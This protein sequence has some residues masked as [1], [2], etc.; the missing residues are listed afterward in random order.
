MAVVCVPEEAQRHELDALLLPALSGAAVAPRAGA[1]NPSEAAWMDGAK[2]AWEAV[3]CSPEL[4][5]YYTR[6]ERTALRGAA[7]WRLR[8]R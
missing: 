6:L 2:A 8:P 3:A 1:A 4:A 7:G 5:E